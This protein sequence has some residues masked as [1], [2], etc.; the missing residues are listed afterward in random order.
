LLND[1][2]FQIGIDLTGMLIF[3]YSFLSRDVSSIA[4]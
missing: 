2:D 1:L 3:V 4:K